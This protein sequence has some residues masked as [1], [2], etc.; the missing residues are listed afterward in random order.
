MNNRFII[1]P[2]SIKKKE[3]TSLKSHFLKINTP[4]IV[5]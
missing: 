2:Q 3:I 5:Y 1:D 4:F